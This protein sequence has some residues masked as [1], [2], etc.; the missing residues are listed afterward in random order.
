M[1][2][3]WLNFKD[4]EGEERRV[5]VDQ[6][7]FVVGR[8]STADL[9]IPNGKLSREHIKI[10][11][12]GDIFVVSDCG[13]SNGTKLN[14]EDL[15]EP[16]ALKNDDE[17]EL[18][19]GLTMVVTMESDAPAVPPPKAGAASEQALP[20]AASAQAAIAS[21]AEPDSAFP[22]W[23]FI[24][25]PILGIVV[26]FF[27]GGLFYLFA[28]GDKE[29]PY[30]RDSVYTRDDEPNSRDD[31]PDSGPSP[32][33]VVKTS[34][35][36]TDSPGNTDL[37][38]TDTG[39]TGP[40]PKNLTDAGKSEQN[41]AEFLRRIAQ[42]DTKAF[43]TGEQAQE[44]SSKIKQVGN[45]SALSDNINSARKNAAQIRS[46]ATAKNL[47]P[48]FLAAAAI[49]KL[50]SSRGD[51]LQTAQGMADIFDKLGTQVGSELA[52]DSL[53]MVA[54]Y[55]QGAA[56]DFMK[57]R[58]MLQDIATK[59]PESSRSIRTIWFLHKQGKI[60]DSEYD[61][62]LRFLA[63]GTIMQNPKDFGVNTE[64]LQL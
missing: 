34:G 15:L 2:E 12:F 39:N 43:L 42:N 59:F 6:D 23:V 38:T 9:S 55:D 32:K 53:L 62:A 3:L 49:T 40:S 52:N 8:L 17:L 44:V 11:R 5:Q 13:S 51:V 48:Q 19:G 63:V 27:V 46:L 7:K 4:D 57:M 20:S 14:G 30:G 36:P 56:G 24:A 25:A 58:N 22:T 18:G 10:E 21:P 64:A 41:A 54:A 26:L 28:G 61:F 1:T 60:T 35:S 37:Q 33:D 45:S 47:K 31:K 50:G 29:K 16:V